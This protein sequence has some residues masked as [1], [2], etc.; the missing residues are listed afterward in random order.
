MIIGRILIGL[1]QYTHA[2]LYKTDIE[3]ISSNNFLSD[4]G[5]AFRKSFHSAYS[6]LLAIRNDG[7]VLP[8]S[9]YN[10]KIVVVKYLITMDVIARITITPDHLS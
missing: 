4:F 7:I 6:I 5:S 10:L 2:E 3:N 9:I 1:A 8:M